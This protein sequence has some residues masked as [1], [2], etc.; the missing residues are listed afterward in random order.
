MNKLSIKQLALML[1]LILGNFNL[2]QSKNNSKWVV[3][4]TI[5]KPNEATKLL[6]S[7]PDWKV[8]IVGDKKTPSSEWEKHKEYI[9]LSP[10]KQLE[11]GYKITKFIPWN[12]Y[13]RKNIGYLYAIENGASVIYETDDDTFIYEDHQLNNPN[14]I[15]ALN[16]KTAVPYFNIFSCFGN[17][18]SWP[19][20][21]PL[22]RITEN[23][24]YTLEGRKEEF[25]PVQSSLV[26]RDP[27]VDAIF[28]L[29]TK[30]EIYFS[31]N[32][33]PITLSEGIM[34]PYNTQNTIVH[35]E[36]FWGLLIPITSTFRT[37]D[38][39]RGYWVQRLLWDIGA[40]LCFTSPMAYQV[41]NDHNLIE[42]FRQELPMYFD[43][44]KLI[45]FLNNWK[46]KNNKLEDRI[47]ELIEQMYINGFLVSQDDVDMAKAWIEDLNRIMY[48]FPETVN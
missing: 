30:K 2:T 14:K 5:N 34:C 23:N 12:H 3:I 6:A 9:Y 32:G 46:S 39:W 42:D 17:N 1:L 8:V 25:C 18:D 33:S 4:T 26:D 27:D 31:K 22:N 29:T 7:L 37:C 41:R 11:L 47:P 16:L 15:N 36:A 40:K 35:K 44:E 43:S 13:C 45:L 19:R 28:R 38:I 48:K 10:E 20:G 24:P 21:Y